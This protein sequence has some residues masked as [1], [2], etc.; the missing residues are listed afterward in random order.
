MGGREGERRDRPGREAGNDRAVNAEPVEQ[1]DE[2][3]GLG[4]G[5]RAT[6][7]GRAEVAHP[8]R[9]DRAEARRNQR[10]GKREPLVVPAEC[11]V[12]HEHRRTGSGRGRGHRSVARG[13]DGR[14]RQTGTRG[15]KPQAE[16]APGERRPCQPRR[17]GGGDGKVQ[18][19]GAGRADPERTPPDPLA[20]RTGR[21]GRGAAIRQPRLPCRSAT[22]R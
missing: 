7:Q 3:L 12:Q 16:A 9:G 11:A 8:R 15:S 1:V 20:R 4:E 13:M 21:P 17:G 18:C 22:S 2:D 6:G 5:P 14:G 19:H 10:R